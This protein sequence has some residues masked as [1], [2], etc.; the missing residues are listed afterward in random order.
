MLQQL[1]DDF[2]NNRYVVNYD[3]YDNCEYQTR[4][5]CIS[6]RDYEIVISTHGTQC[7]TL[8][9]KNEK[10]KHCFFHSKSGKKYLL[11]WSDTES[12]FSRIYSDIGEI[13]VIDMEWINFQSK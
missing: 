12:K 6:K 4:K 8:S 9:P 7:H 5:I 13:I 2:E 3:E 11:W 1:I 10:E